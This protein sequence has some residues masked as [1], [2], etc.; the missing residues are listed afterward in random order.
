MEVV[1]VCVCVYPL[2]MCGSGGGVVVPA[3]W[4]RDRP[5][6]EAVSYTLCAPS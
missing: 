1:C 6:S 4:A 5:G 2:V 3:S